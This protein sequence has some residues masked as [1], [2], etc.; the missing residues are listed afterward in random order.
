MLIFISFSLYAD[1][2]KTL[3]LQKG[4]KSV[5]KYNK[6]IKVSYYNHNIAVANA[7]VSKSPLFPQINTFASQTYLANQPEAHFGTISAP[8]SEKD[9]SS[10]G[11]DAMQTLYDFGGSASLYKSKKTNIKISDE[12]TGIVKN[13]T[14]L[15][16]IITYF[17]CLDSNKMVLVAKE[18]V[19]SFQIHLKDAQALFKQGVITK[20]D[21]LQAQVKLADA[22]QKLLN[23]KTYREIQ[24]EMLNN[25]MGQ[26]LS[27]RWA[28]QENPLM[29]KRSSITTAIKTAEEKR[30]EIKVLD[31]QS[32]SMD[33]YEK[34]L[35][36]EYL[37]QLFVE[38]SYSYVN[39][40]Y[41]L[42]KNQWA[43]ILGVNLNI[44]N[45]WKTRSRVYKVE[46][47]QK[48][49]SEEKAKTIEDIKLEVK[50]NYQN[51]LTNFQNIKVTEKT[52][53][54]A[55]ENLRINTLKYREGVG[56]ATD[57]I[58]AISLLTTA[59]TDY[60]TAIYQYQEAQANLFY[61]MGDNL[62]AVYTG[63]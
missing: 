21:L 52:I 1:K 36:A 62:A 32:K 13:L 20:N 37:P 24:C 26:P 27:D 2:V 61:S 22:K 23:A 39:N 34:Y 4:I 54:Q 38:G 14:I 43:L 46:E 3:T 51:V 53:S 12:K 63:R 48:Q 29:V 10:F 7:N 15:N 44:F 42:P 16:F 28:L 33:Y 17:N 35:R 58:D 47:Q 5:I 9:F 25:I 31:N 56:T 60:W 30:K 59:E 19:K 57:V 55:K 18:E 50:S 8:I 11:I 41:E 40:P 45:G 6:E 49:V